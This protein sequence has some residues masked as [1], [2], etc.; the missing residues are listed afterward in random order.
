M[1]QAR[2]DLITAYWENPPGPRSGLR[3][4]RVI[5]GREYE[6]RVRWN[7]SLTQIE[8]A[9]VLGTTLMTINRWVR[10]GRLKDHKVRGKSMIRLSRNQAHSGGAPPHPGPA[11]LPR[12]IGHARLAALATTRQTAPPRAV[13]R[14][15]GVP[16]F[17]AVLDRIEA[18]A[19]HQREAFGNELGARGIEW[20][21]GQVRAA[22][23]G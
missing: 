16:G 7:E 10:G 3:L 19:T 22:L 1:G 21:A 13:S 5:N 17:E 12:G 2:P 14:Y 15:V 23:Q 9:A 4:S 11:N 6:A 20:A 18:E 8:A